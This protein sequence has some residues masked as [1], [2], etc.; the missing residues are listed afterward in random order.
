MNFW[1]ALFGKKNES[2]DVV[3]RQ[4]SSTDYYEYFGDLFLFKYPKTWRKEVTEEGFL[5][6]VPPDAQMVRDEATGREELDLGIFLSIYDFRERNDLQGQ[7]L[8]LLVER[9]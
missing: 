3:Q 4:E 9:W 2:M 1:K 6:V 7:L 5:F 8:T